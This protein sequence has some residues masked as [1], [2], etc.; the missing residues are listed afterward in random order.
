MFILTGVNME[1]IVNGKKYKFSECLLLMNQK[2]ILKKELLNNLNNTINGVDEPL[3]KST[4][5]NIFY[6]REL[7]F[8]YYEVEN[9]INILEPTI[10]T[11]TLVELNIYNFTKHLEEHIKNLNLND[12][13]EI[14]IIFNG[15]SDNEYRFI[16]KIKK[17]KEYDVVIKIF[18]NLEQKYFEIGFD[19]S[20]LGKYEYDLSLFNTFDEFYEMRN[21]EEVS[22]IVNL[23]NYYFYSPKET[24]FKDFFEKFTFET[25]IIIY[26][27]IDDKYSLAKIINY[28]TNQHKKRDIMIREGEHLSRILNY[29][30]GTKFDFETFFV[31]LNYLDKK[32]K[33]MSYEQFIKHIKEDLEIVIIIEP[34]TN[35]CDTKFFEDIINKLD[36]NSSPLILIY[37]KIYF[38]CLNLLIKANEEII[39]LTNK[40]NQ[41]KDKFFDYI[42]INFI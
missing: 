12:K 17:L 34:E 38:T 5:K 6:G 24:N 3:I 41:T 18:S 14:E 9:L 27:F 42:Q 2:N 21:F 15:F 36:C 4:N 7:T 33:I 35:L 29:I 26:S 23:D 39:R 28:K 19:Y 22:A 31:N 37:R 40:N 25:L 11:K 8:N 30:K 20:E 32:G 13:I 1:P 10:S 16:D